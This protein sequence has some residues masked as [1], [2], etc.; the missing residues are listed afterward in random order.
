MDMDDAILFDIQELI[1]PEAFTKISIYGAPKLKKQKCWCFFYNQ[2]ISRVHEHWQRSGEL[3]PSPISSEVS[4]PPL[5]KH[6]MGQRMS[7]A[8]HVGVEKMKSG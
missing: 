6:S 3:D 4:H 5:C 7:L 2:K 8:C 1:C